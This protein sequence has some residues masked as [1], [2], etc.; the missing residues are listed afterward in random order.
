MKV[1]G[2]RH[3]YNCTTALLHIVDTYKITV[4]LVLDF[5]KPF[6]S[7]NDVT[8]LSILKTIGFCTEAEQ[9]LQSYCSIT[10]KLG[11]SITFVSSSY[12]WLVSRFFA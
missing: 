7:I 3:C 12:F 1:V 4:L 10:V 6:D 11:K 5:I 9:L 2:L 8:L